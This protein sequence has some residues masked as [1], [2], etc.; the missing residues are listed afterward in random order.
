MHVPRHRFQRKCVGPPRAT[1]Q[2]RVCGVRDSDP[3]ELQRFRPMP[4]TERPQGRNALAHCMKSLFDVVGCWGGTS[5]EVAFVCVGSGG[6]VGTR[7]VVLQAM[8]TGRQSAWRW[9]K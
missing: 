5:G 2:V 7:V 4:P 1:P 8:G 9:F 3:T 6:R